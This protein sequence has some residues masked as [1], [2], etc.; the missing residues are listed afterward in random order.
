MHLRCRLRELRGTR[1]LRAVEA[2]TG[3]SRAYLS[4]IERGKLLPPDRLVAELE[5]A[6]GAPIERW[7][8]PLAILKDDP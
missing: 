5:R 7:Y 6:Y 3:I 4:L 8:W 2:E 1:G